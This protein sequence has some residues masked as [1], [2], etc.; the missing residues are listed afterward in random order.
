MNRLYHR[1]KKDAHCS[2]MMEVYDFFLLNSCLTFDLYLSN[3]YPYRLLPL[4]T[5][6][7]DRNQ[8]F[9]S[10]TIAVFQSYHLFITQFS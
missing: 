1:N 4:K 6:K 10:F 5:V 7:F 3:I 2:Q 8:V 9:L